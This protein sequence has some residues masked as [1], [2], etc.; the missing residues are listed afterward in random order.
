MQIRGLGR[1]KHIRAQSQKLNIFFFRKA[2]NNKKREV[3]LSKFSNI[4]F[5]F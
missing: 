2:N 1:E 4:S 5:N 3:I